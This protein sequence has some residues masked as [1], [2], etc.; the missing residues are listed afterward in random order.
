MTFSYVLVT[1]AAVFLL[2]LLVVTLLASLIGSLYLYVVFPQLAGQV[3]RQYAFVAA[4]QASS[5][6]LNPQSTF[7]PGRPA[8]LQ[9]LPDEGNVLLPQASAANIPYTSTLLPDTQAVEFGLLIAPD[10]T[11]LA[12]SYPRHYPNQTP[13]S[14]LLPDRMG[15]IAAALTS[16]TAA[17]G[18]ETTQAGLTTWVVVPVWSRDRRPIG[19]IYLQEPVRGPD[20]QLANHP[21]ELDKAALLG[22]LSGLA[23]LVVTAPIGGLFGLVTTRSL[24]RR[25]RRLVTATTEFANGQYDQ[26]VPVARKDEIGQLEEHFNRMA[27]QLAESI[28]ARQELAEQNARMAERARISRELH[29]AV[30]QDLFSLRMLAGG[31]QRALPPDSP[32][33]PQIASLQQMATTMIREMRALLLELRPAQLEHLGL[34]EALEDLATAY[35]TRLGITV[36]TA[37]K[38]APLSAAVEQAILRITQEAL[39]NAA[40]HAD[41]TAITLE[42][43][44]QDQTI[45]LTIGDNGQGFEPT[46]DETQHG[47]GLRSMQERVQ[48][49]GGTFTLESAPG[50][51]TRV[52]VSFPCLPAP[53]AATGA[54]Q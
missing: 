26:R 6:G 42:L 20:G 33:A 31:L 5:T 47:F 16:G 3:A 25:I 12:S 39:S 13:V 27:G 29:D 19:A 37:I 21:P 18:T 14:T 30:S 50:Q 11:V 10:E 34:A 54:E 52:Q 44:P 17:S 43:T 23:L 7:L 24:V 46:R 45:T 38:T 15:A 28:R 40:R 22:L 2:E 35:R 41:A 4:L 51:G 32:L 1:V 8:S 53:D 9:P 48:E 36:M 49:L